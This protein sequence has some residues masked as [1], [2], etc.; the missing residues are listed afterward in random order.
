MA[1]RAIL[2]SSFARSNRVLGQ[3]S[4]R[5]MA[6]SPHRLVQ[7]RLYSTKEQEMRDRNAIGPATWRSAALFILTG[8]GLYYY[9]TNEK[10]AVIAKKEAERATVKTGRPAVGGPF[11]L[12]DQNGNEFTEQKLKGRWSMV[13]FGFT[14]CPDICPEELDKMGAVVDVAEKKYGENIIQPIFI[15]CDPARDSVD[16]VKKYLSEFHPRMVGLTGSYDAVK[17]ACKK[18]RVYFSTPPNAQPGDDYLVD[19]SIYFYLMDPNGEYVEAFGKSIEAAQV[20]QSFERA[21]S[22]WDKEHPR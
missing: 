22:E 21:K 14:N 18:Y 9:F 8:A 4:T 15:S 5:P 3:V 16:Q 12:I 2:R 10:A 1:S 20:Y 6:F 7:Q 13:Y 19:H 17:A 11:T